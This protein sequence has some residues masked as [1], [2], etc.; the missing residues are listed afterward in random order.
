MKRIWLV[1]GWSIGVCKASDG[2]APALELTS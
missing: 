2:H 1:V